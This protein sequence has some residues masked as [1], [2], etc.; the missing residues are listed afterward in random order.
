M[1][2]LNLRIFLCLNLT[3]LLSLSGSSVTAQEVVNESIFQFIN[4]QKGFPKITIDTD[5]KQLFRKSHKE[6]YQPAEIWIHDVDEQE[7]FQLAGRVRARGNMRKKVCG[8]PPIK[9]D[10]NKGSL[11]SL[12]FQKNDK[13]KL[14]F[15]CRDRSSDQQRLFKEY[16]VYELYALIDSNA[17]QARLVEFELKNGPVIEHKFTGMLVEDEVEYAFRKSA[18]VIE[19][20]KLYEAS[21]ERT[22]FLK[23][24]FF[25]YMIANTDFSIS[26]KHNLEMVKLPNI[27][28]VVALPYDFDYSG[29]VGH[30]YAVP[31]ESLGIEDVHERYFFNFSVT[32]PEFNATV[33][34]YKSM[35]GDIYAAIDSAS[36]LDEKSR[37]ECKEYLEGFFDLLDRPQRLKPLIVR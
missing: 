11:D 15:P 6:E 7:I 35:E 23:M 30:I 5:V 17:I 4:S 2:S 16:L 34:Y 20:G 10:F 33:D 36:Y 27:A 29:F 25:Q 28:R 37:K 24:T 31:H 13:L 21:L 9:L 8:I 32:E 19:S 18:K 26:N 3:M 12:G 22:N 1:H 14:V